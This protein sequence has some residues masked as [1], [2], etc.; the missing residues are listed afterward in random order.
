MYGYK[1]EIYRRVLTK[2]VDN[3]SGINDAV[4]EICE[5][6]YKNL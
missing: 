5:K 3:I 6:G 1:Q 2:A 4:D